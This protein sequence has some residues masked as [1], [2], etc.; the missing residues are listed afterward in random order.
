MPESTD[1]ISAITAGGVAVSALKIAFDHAG[2]IDGS[3]RAL[4]LGHFID[5]WNQRLKNSGY[6]GHEIPEGPMNGTN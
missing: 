1:Q 3:M 4:V 5:E 2:L 6:I